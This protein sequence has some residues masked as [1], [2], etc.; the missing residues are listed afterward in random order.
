MRF[1]PRETGETALFEE[2][3]FKRAVFPFS[4]GK[5]RVSQG[6][7]NRGSLISVPLA[8]REFCCH[9]AGSYLGS[10]RSQVMISTRVKH[11][12]FTHR[13][14]SFRGAPSTVRHFMT[15][16]GCSFFKKGPSKKGK[17]P[18]RTGGSTI[19]KLIWERE[20]ALFSRVWGS[21]TVRNLE[22]QNLLCRAFPGCFR[23]CSGFHSGNAYPYSGHLQFLYS[24]EELT[25]AVAVSE[26]KIQQRSRRRG[27]FPAAIFLAGKCPNLGRDGSSRCRKIGESFSGSVEVCPKKTFPAGNFGQPLPS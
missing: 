7:E 6:V 18:N 17:G 21:P 3:F 2:S 19:L 15:S 20:S 14:A 9:G 10:E 23:I 27:Q 13:R 16:S 11:Y 1:F 22:I 8:L 12:A 4:R 24:S 25:K 26:E 5:H